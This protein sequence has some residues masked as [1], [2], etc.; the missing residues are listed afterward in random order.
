MPPITRATLLRSTAAGSALAAAGLLATGLPGRAAAPDDVTI[1]GVALAMERLEIA[2]YERALDRAGLRGEVRE[3]AE[4]A[5]GHERE[6]ERYL[7]GALG[8][9]SGI[10]RLALAPP[11]ANERDFLRLAIAM[12]DILVSSRNGQAGNLSK[13]RLAAVATIASVE[14]R[15]SAWVRDLAGEAPAPDAVD[16]SLGI[17]AGTERLRKEG[18]IT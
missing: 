7:E 17:E 1:L 8:S 5:L 2:F 13:R 10:P 14:A 4:T 11:V 6:H 15:H 16:P 12:E 3:F 18:L 9:P